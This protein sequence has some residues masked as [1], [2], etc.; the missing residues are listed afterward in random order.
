MDKNGYDMPNDSNFAL[1]WAAEYVVGPLGGNM[2]NWRFRSYGNFGD[3]NHRFY[4]PTK[5]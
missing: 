1:F 5:R 3:K 2:N 4:L